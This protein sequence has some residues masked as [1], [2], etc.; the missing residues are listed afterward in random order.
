M[1]QLRYSNYRE[2]FV[3]G[4]FSISVSLYGCKSNS[5]TQNATLKSDAGNVTVTKP[6]HRDF[7]AIK[8]SG[9]IRLITRYNSSSYFLHKG[10]ERGFEYEF[11][12][13]FAKEHGLNVEVAI[14]QNGQSAIDMLNSGEGDVIAANYVVT[15]ARKKYVDFTQPYNL[16]NQVIVLPEKWNNRPDST[17]ADLGDITISVRYNSSYYQ[18]LKNLQSEGYTFKIDTV[19]EDWDTEALMY[20]VEQGKFEATV[21]DDNLFRAANTYIKGLTAGPVI[22]KDDTVAWAIRK[23]SPELQKAMNQF[24]AKH[25]KL[26]GDQPPKRSEFLNVL[27]Q[28]YFEDEAQI[29]ALKTPVK[30]KYAGLL[31]PY[32]KLIRPIADS[33]GIDWRMVVAIAAQESKFDP[34]AK[35]WTGAIGLMQISPRFSTYSVPQLLNVKTNI[36]EGIRILEDQLNHYAYMD[37]TDRW[38]FALATYNA[39]PGHITDARRLVMDQ[40]KNPNNWDNVANAL[41]MLMKRKYYDDARFGFCRGIETVSYVND[42][43]SRYQMYQTITELAMQTDDKKINPVLG[44]SKTINAP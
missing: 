33:M 13:E 30:T 26:R 18:T 40:Y 44:I 34:T 2:I 31:S 10:M 14:I 11:L 3:V 5:E 19:S 43:M 9:V 39:G 38:K 12:S 7:D 27:R 36:R 32:D 35:S 17:L 21:S 42:I 15:P 29:V 16:V 24:L 25:F 4:L 41:I 37:S 20:G 8:K 23:N 1:A 6:I 28:R 22:E